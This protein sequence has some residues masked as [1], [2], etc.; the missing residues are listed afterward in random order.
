MTENEMLEAEK[1]WCENCCN[2]DKGQVQIDGCANCKLTGTIAYAQESGKECKFF[3][4]P[5]ENVIVPPCKPGDKLF[6][7]DYSKKIVLDC[8]VLQINTTRYETR[9]WL[10]N[11]KC[12]LP[13]RSFSIDEFGEKVYP[14][15]EEAEKA[16]K[17]GGRG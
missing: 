9:V 12:R 4:V 2:W 1:Y 10:N 7:V 8:D 11:P 13:F 15:K 6:I 17:G 3:N 5:S 16:L 14:T